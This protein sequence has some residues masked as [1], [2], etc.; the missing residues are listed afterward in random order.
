MSAYPAPCLLG[1]RLNAFRLNYLASYRIWIQIGGAWTAS[2][3][4]CLVDS[5][6]IADRLNDVPNTL[7]ATVRGLKP[8]E[9]QIV[10]V[11]LGTKNAPPIFVGTILRVTR[12]WGADNP[13][14]MLYNIEATDPTWL[15]NA[16]IVSAKYTNQ[17]ASAIAADLLT[18]APAGFTGQIQPDLPVLQEISFTNTTIMDA[19]V[20]LAT[21]IGGYTLCDY[22]SR[23]YLA[24]APP[25]ITPA[26][27]NAAHQSLSNVSYVRDLTQIVTR[28]I[29]EGG[30]GNALTAVLAGSTILPVDVIAWYA[31][32]GGFVRSGPQRIAYT[33]ITAGGTGAYV[34]S[35]TAPST[36]PT[37]ALGAGTSALGLGYYQYAYTWL[38]ASGETLPSPI[39]AVVLAPQNDPTSGPT[40]T[41]DLS[42]TPSSAPLAVG[43]VVDIAVQ[44]AYD[45][46]FT[47]G[48]SNL[49]IGQTGLVVP[50]W[51]FNSNNTAAAINY[52]ASGTIG[53]PAKFARVYWRK[54]GGP[55]LNNG[56]HTWGQGDYVLR[57]MIYNSDN[58]GVPGAGNN[59]YRTAVAGI[60][61]GP[62][63]VTARKVYRTAASAGQLKL[64]TTIADNTTTAL[65]SYDNTADG[66]LGANA[67]TVDT[68]GIVQQTKQVLAGSTSILVTSVG[69][70]P[71][72]GGFAVI[73]QQVIRFTGVSSNSLIGIPASGA[74][75]LV[76]SVSWGMAITMAPSLTGVTGIVYDIRQGDQVNLVAIMDDQ[77][78][79]QTLAALVGGTGIRESLLQD[80]RISL[81]EA[82]ARGQALLVAHRSVLETFTHRS[83]DPNTR[84]GALVDVNLPAPTDIVG[85]FRLQDV[86]IRT[87]NPRGLAPPVYDASSSSQ[88][89]TFEDLLRQ[90][91]NTAPPPATGEY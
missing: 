65:A 25:V 35:G 21:R 67:P 82:S 10:R 43:D 2:G 50:R 46:A 56:L 1:N 68:A 11:A 84:S 4:D 58:V 62:T 28:A 44:F 52:I 13:R 16:V 90:I 79:Q 30:G 45:T 89:F 3:Q 55:W 32:G 61:V 66:A 5:L 57:G 34:G 78:A 6:T 19:F 86:T 7:I 36:A 22:A 17:S 75:A 24:L 27:L 23:V 15:L 54:N 14:H 12:I 87:F 49:V 47:Q 60:A 42:T 37:A 81:T 9:G 40:M 31:A 72:A 76:Q 85:T 91:S 80:G 41:P 26:P 73:G 70:F 69:P 18:R 74:G 77:T 48:V 39:G 8:I 51:N 71:A 53:P 33:G 29:V 83:R 88:L 20:Q 38:T 63:G 59:L 64:H